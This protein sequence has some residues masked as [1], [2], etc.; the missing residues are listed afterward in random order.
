VI[1]QSLA[2]ICLVA[3]SLLLPVRAFAACSIGK[4][5][6]LPVR[7]LGMRALMPVKMNGTA[8]SLIVDS[9]STFSVLSPASAAALKLRVGADRLELSGTRGTTGVAVVTVDKFALADIPLRQK[10]QFL[11]GGNDFGSDAAGLLG[12]NILGIADT[13]YDLSNGVIRM[14]KPT[15]CRDRILAYWAGVGQ[16]YGELP[17]ADT[18]KLSWRII[19]MATLNGQPIRVL[20]DTGAPT[21]VLT[22]EAARRAGVT[23]DTPGVVPTGVSYGLGR[24]TYRTWV[25]PFTTFEIGGEQINHTRLRF[26]DLTLSDADMLLGM[27]FFLS[28]RIYVANSQHKVYFTLYGGPVFNLASLPAPAMQDPSASSPAAATADDPGQPRSA[29]EFAARGSALLNRRDLTR[30]IADLTQACLLDPTQPEYFYQRAL[31]YLADRQAV[32]AQADVDQALMLKPDFVDALVMR[33]QLELS[34]NDLAAARLD[35]DATDRAAPSQSD[36]RFTLARMYLADGVPDAAV[37]QMDLWIEVHPDDARLPPALNIRCVGRV[38][39]NSKLNKAQ[40]DCTAALRKEPNTPG[41]LE[42]LGWVYFRLGK[43]DKSIQQFDAALKQQPRL[44]QSLYGRGIDELRL[45]KSADAQTDLD[46]ARALQP[47]IGDRLRGY[48]IAP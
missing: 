22:S 40:S 32:P 15:D 5:A 27:D 39:S 23:P 2:L 9:G 38:W 44:V 19:G 46:A 33:A 18:G 3:A 8:T 1:K 24:G 17:I 21:S 43:F 41:F 11:V 28:H 7:L 34:K 14:M 20:F 42:S 47:D 30:A 13:E 12:E 26:A 29:A 6:D 10:T 31:A 45:G 4:V 35:L 36:V 48:G 25:G 37:H 16:A